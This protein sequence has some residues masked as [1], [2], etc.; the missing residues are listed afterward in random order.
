MRLNM[1]PSLG[2]TNTGESQQENDR[3]S[4]A[5]GTGPLAMFSFRG[6][7]EQ[8]PGSSVS[9]S[10]HPPGDYLNPMRPNPSIKSAGRAEA[11]PTE[12]LI[13]RAHG[14]DRGAIAQLISRYQGHLLSLVRRRLG[15]ALRSQ[16]ESRDVA[17]DVMLRAVQD[18]QGFRPRGPRSFLSWMSG[19]AENRLR[20]LAR[21]R[22]KGYDLPVGIEIG[23]QLEDPAPEPGVDGS[24]AEWHLLQ[25]GLE[26]L[27]WKNREV[28]R[29]RNIEQLSFREVGHLMGR[30]EEAVWMMHKRAMA[31]LIGVIHGMRGARED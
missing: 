7:N 13:R 24:E 8:G 2:R 19:I 6:F 20:N 3:F 1:R 27:E 17:Q 5:A 16:V 26:R 4:Q 21:D 25:R 9:L 18:V 29:L 28:V 11:H 30:S 12:V 15:P 14:G 23:A 22:S 10:Y 31:E